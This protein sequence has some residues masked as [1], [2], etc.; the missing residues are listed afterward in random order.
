M[1]VLDDILDGVRA[2]L[3]ERQASTSL[4]DLKAMAAARPSALDAEAVLRGDGVSVIAEVKRSSPSKGALAAI[5][6]AVAVGQAP[7]F[8]AI[9][10]PADLST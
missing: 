6:Q 4:D 10:P 9:H 5:G 1:T 2:D 8:I 7:G 3:A